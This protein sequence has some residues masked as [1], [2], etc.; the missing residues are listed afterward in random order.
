MNETEMMIAV[1]TAVLTASVTLVAVHL[2]YRGNLRQMALQLSH[3]ETEKNAEVR[4]EKLEELYIVAAKYSKMLASHFFPYLDVMMGKYDYNAALDMT[5]ESG[6]DQQYDFDRLEMIV[7][8]YFPELQAPLKE[9]FEMRDSANEIM[10]DHKR[11]YKNG[12]LDGSAFVKPMHTAI[13]D[14]IDAS[15]QLKQA[16][17]TLGAG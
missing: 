1:G 13:G 16:I 8:L 17:V 9:L 4:R 12:Q 10:L 11:Q 15:D 2:A 5:I 3:A 6:K 7:D 14:V